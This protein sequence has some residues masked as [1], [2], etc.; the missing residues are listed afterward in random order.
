MR[1]PCPHC[2][3]RDHSEFRYGG[4]ATK[5]RP[6]HGTGDVVTKAAGGD[7]TKQRPKLGTGDIDAWHDYYFLF[8][9]PKSPHTEYWQ[10][11]LGCRQWFKLTRN[12]ATNAKV[13]A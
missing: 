6:P 2:G 9:N 5:I 11:V 4:D 1:I 13:V 3:E 7:A 12:T 8:E 10:H